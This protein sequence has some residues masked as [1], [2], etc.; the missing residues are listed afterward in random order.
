[1]ENTQQHIPT[2]AQIIDESICALTEIESNLRTA[3]ENGDYEYIDNCRIDEA[4]EKIEEALTE[5]HN[6]GEP[7]D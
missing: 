2:P 1:M 5:L 6:I 3:W 7:E 4:R